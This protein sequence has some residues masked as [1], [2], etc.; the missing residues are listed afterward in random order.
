MRNVRSSTN[1]LSRARSPNFGKIAA[2][3]GVV[4]GMAGNAAPCRGVSVYPEYVRNSL[5]GGAFA[6]CEVVRGHVTN[7]SPQYADCSG[8]DLARNIKIDSV[9][10]LRPTPA[11]NLGP[12]NLIADA[13]VLMRSKSVGC[14]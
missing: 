8:M 6:A 2:A 1:T 3:S 13:V 11:W 7:V 10:R 14:I 9:S 4:N 5:W 12:M